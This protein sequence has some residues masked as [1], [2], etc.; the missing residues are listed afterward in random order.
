[1]PICEPGVLLTA[2]PGMRFKYLVTVLR[3]TSAEFDWLTSRRGAAGRGT[4]DRGGVRDNGAYGVGRPREQPP[5]DNR[6]MSIWTHLGGAL[7]AQ[8]PDPAANGIMSFVL[9]E[10]HRS[11]VLFRNR[12]REFRRA[13]SHVISRFGSAKRNSGA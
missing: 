8:A 10:L 12:A 9:F 5:T 13:P 11:F 7:R 3:L 6:L 1:M 2:M 4:A